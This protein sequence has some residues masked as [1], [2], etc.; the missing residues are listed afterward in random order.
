MYKRQGLSGNLRSSIFTKYSPPQAEVGTNTKYAP[1]VE[2]G[3]DHMEPRH[4]EGSQRVY[5]VGYF[6]YA[7][8]ELGKKMGGLLNNIAG[9]IERK[10]S[11]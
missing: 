7:L 1:F 11:S 10:W 5:G 6:E 9:K 8:Q 4:I 2:Y 3:T